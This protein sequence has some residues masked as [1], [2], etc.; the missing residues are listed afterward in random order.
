MFDRVTRET[1]PTAAISILLDTSSSMGYGYKPAYVPAND[2]CISMSDAL[3]SLPGFAVSVLQYSYTLWLI[4]PF[5]SRIQLREFIPPVGG[6]DTVGAILGA[7]PQ[8]L[9]RRETNKVFVVLTDGE[10]L[11]G[12]SVEE[13][14]N[15]GIKV[16]FVRFSDATKPLDGIDADLQPY[17]SDLS[18]LPMVIAGV[19]QKVMTGS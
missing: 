11:L 13:A 1:A 3:Q 14:N 9:T 17:C 4:K 2:A 16:C 15:N 5:E 8:M 10:T 6:T 12:N 19:I 7:I 18:D